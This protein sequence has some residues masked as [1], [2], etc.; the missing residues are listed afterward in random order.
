MKSGQP[1]LDTSPLEVTNISKH[2]FR[3]LLDDRE[4][5]V[6]SSDFPWFQQAAISAVLNVERPRADH[7]YWPDL[8]IDLA[9]ESIEHPER[10]SL[11]SKDRG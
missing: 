2:G 1:G 8:D 11:V 7:L 5:F 10:F 9:V 6:P 4:L 3:L